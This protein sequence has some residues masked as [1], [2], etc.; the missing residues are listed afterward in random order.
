MQAALAGR[1]PIVLE[2]YEEASE[3]LG[4]DLWAL[5]QEGPPAK[6]GTTQVTQPAMLTAGTACW[7]VWRSVGGEIPSVLAGHSL[8]E[9]TAL[10]SANAMSFED[11]VKLVQFRG[12]LMQEACPIGESAMAAIIGLSDAEVLEVCLNAS[13][14]GVAE[15]V[16][17]NSPGQVVVAGHKRAVDNVVALAREAG[18]RRALLLDVSVPSHSSLMRSAGERLAEALEATHFNKPDI[19]VISS[20]EVRPYRNADDIRKL[21]TRQV[22]SPVQWVRTTEALIAA[23]ADTIIECGPGKVLAGLTR[24]IDR[25]VSSTCLDSVESLQAALN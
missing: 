14:V 10:L 5:V 16:N 1:Y 23:G 2:T 25:A 6:L 13:T 8:G 4:Y 12:A 17:F 22:Y 11:A 7:R 21:L 19:P 20:V 15:A 18:A 9:Y 3:I 24:R